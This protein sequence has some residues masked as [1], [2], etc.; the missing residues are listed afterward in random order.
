MVKQ[1][2]ILLLGLTGVGKSSFINSLANYLTYHSFA[3]AL[4]ANKPICLVSTFFEYYDVNQKVFA[5]KISGSD[6]QNEDLTTGANSSTQNPKIYTFRCES[7]DLEINIM[8]SP[9]TADTRGIDMDKK[10]IQTILDAVG[11]FSQ[12]HLI[13]VLLKSSEPRLTEELQFGLNE[14]LM[15]LHKNSVSNLDFI[16]TNSRAADYKL[17]QVSAPLKEYLKKLKKSKKIDIEILPKNVFC[18]DNEAFRAQCQWFQYPGTKDAKL[19][20]TFETSWKISFQAF[21]RLI[22]R[23]LEIDAH[24]VAET[25]SLNEARSAILLLVDPLSTIHSTLQSCVKDYSKN[26]E[27]ICQKLRDKTHQDSG[28]EAQKI[29]IPRTVCIRCKAICHKNCKLRSLRVKTQADE[30]LQDC[31]VF[32]R[33][34]GACFE[35]G[36]SVQVHMRELYVTQKVYRTEKNNFINLIG[37]SNS[38]QGIQE[39]VNQV[40][41]LLFEEKRQIEE[42]MKKF[43][44]FLR[45]NS[46]IEYNNIL[47]R[48]IELEVNSNYQ[49]SPN[50]YNFY[51]ELGWAN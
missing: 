19:I 12:L 49:S 24:D 33:D 22:N 23:G 40:M 9:G 51:P 27:I 8:D 1:L 6:D 38:P 20:E 2:N 7:E 18:V 47:E 30:R 15:H 43:G 42:A 3:E 35:C 17:G 5:V 21:Q 48:R 44:T 34:T 28:I 39:K 16:I 32:D 31:A 14:L 4:A 26:Y 25:V 10:N 11:T 29:Q 50:I 13:C 45:N 36:C 46:I 37:D 41:T